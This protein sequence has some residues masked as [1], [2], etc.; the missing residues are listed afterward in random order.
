MRPWWDSP[1]LVR[2]GAGA[3]YDVSTKILYAEL[4]G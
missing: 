4:H 1:G 3:L 2:L